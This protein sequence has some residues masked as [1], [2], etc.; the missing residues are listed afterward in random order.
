M[1]WAVSVG[2]WPGN[3]PRF[4]ALAGRRLRVD[5]AGTRREGGYPVAPTP[6]DEP[7]RGP[8]CA[9][10]PGRL[11]AVVERVGTEAAKM[12]V[13]GW[14]IRGFPCPNRDEENSGSHEGLSRRSPARDRIGKAVTSRIE[15]MRGIDNED[16]R[17][18]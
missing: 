16:R 10:E 4:V 5:R 18:S 14:K 2:R 6:R 13:S 7:E 12:A 9:P 8:N 1:H 15:I 11:V 17:H 3:I